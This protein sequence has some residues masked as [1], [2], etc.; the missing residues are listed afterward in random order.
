MSVKLKL[1]NAII[2]LL[3]AQSFLFAQTN[4][5]FYHQTFAPSEGLISNKG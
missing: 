3:M 4:K 5:L 2:C 1:S